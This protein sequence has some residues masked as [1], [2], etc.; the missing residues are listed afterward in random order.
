MIRVRIDV[1]DLTMEMEGHAN[2]PRVGDSDLVCC[3]A[4]TI[5]QLLVYSLEE[6]SDRHGGAVKLQEEME[7]GKLHVHAI[8]KEW[9]RVS[10]RTRY[11]IAAEGMEMLQEKYPAY[12]RIDHEEED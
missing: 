12:I 9:A 7:K 2:A 11:H 1:N 10:V 3:A 8:C 4:S 5:G 6:Y